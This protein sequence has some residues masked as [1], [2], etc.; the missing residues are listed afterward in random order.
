MNEDKLALKLNNLE[1][2]TLHAIKTKDFSSPDFKVIEMEVGGVAL[3]EH[4][5]ELYLII[6]TD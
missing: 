4:P 5:Y 2:V 1:N 3:I 6:S